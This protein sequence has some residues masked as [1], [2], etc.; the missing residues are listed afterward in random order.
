MHDL[1]DHELILK[2]RETADG[3]VIAVLFQRYTHLVYGVSLKYLEDTDQ[4]KDAVMEIFEALMTDLL[5]HDILNFKSWL[6]S[7]TRN[8]CLMALRK[9]RPLRMVAEALDDN[10][11]GDFVEFVHDAHQDN[12]FED[13]TEDDLKTALGSLKEQQRQC[14]ELFFLEGKSYAEVGEH[15]GL[16]FKEVK[17]HIQNGKR[18]LKM[19]LEEILARK[20]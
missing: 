10:S 15:L 13:Y 8:H 12:I 11:E 1:P 5:E 2:Y 14:V 3:E 7:V 17:S 19:K 9:K 4:A 6:H 18:N 16:S 20:Q